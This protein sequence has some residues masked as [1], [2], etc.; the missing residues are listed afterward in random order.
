MK[1]KKII[2]AALVIFS[3][4][5]TCLFS[6][7]NQ[8]NTEPKPY[9]KDEFIQ[10]LQDLRRFEII[11]LGSMPFV[12]LNTAIVFNGINYATGKTQTFN[13]LATADY[14]PDEMKTVILTSLCI[15]AGIGLTD[16][17]VRIV[18]RHKSYKKIDLSDAIKIEIEPDEPDKSE[19]PVESEET[20]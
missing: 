19:E 2:I 11:T 15:S 9:S 7:S 20:E 16:F 14:K 1:L 17:I 3:I 4:I 10:P 18:K 13:P 8:K 12:T 6:Q 5:Q